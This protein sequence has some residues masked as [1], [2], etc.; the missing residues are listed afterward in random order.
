M[1]ALNK[2]CHIKDLS[3]RYAEAMACRNN[4]AFKNGAVKIFNDFFIPRGSLC[5]IGA[6][7]FDGKTA[8]AINI[9]AEHC[10]LKNNP[11]AL[12]SLQHGYEDIISKLICMLYKIPLFE[13]YK[14]EHRI[15]VSG[16]CKEIKKKPFYLDTSSII[17]VRDIKERILDVRDNISLVIIDHLQLLQDARNNTGI[18]PIVFML[19]EFAKKQN[20]PIILF[21]GLA[22][23]NGKNN[24][25]CMEEFRI[26]GD[27]ES[28]A[29]I[30]GYIYRPCFPTEAEPGALR[31][32][33][34]C[35]CKNKYSETRDIELE[36]NVHFHSFLAGVG[37]MLI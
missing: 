32:A 11:T 31:K 1:K 9:A 13:F 27:L 16:A 22:E 7:E 3:E 17:S 2:L 6:R 29:D 37:E 23:R 8:L 25:P 36:F 15:G 24:R 12:F 10:I 20:I 30:L 5:I 33:I 4:A 19:K 21:C 26:L 18:E 35:I 14:E 34:L 28:H